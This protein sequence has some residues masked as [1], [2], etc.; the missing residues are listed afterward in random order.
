LINAN[1]AVLDYFFK[2]R[3]TGVLDGFRQIYIQPKSLFGFLNRKFMG[4]G[5]E[6]ESP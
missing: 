6:A 5:H 4:Y 3:A 1:S 2:K